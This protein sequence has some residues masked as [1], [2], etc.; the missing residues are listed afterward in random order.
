MKPEGHKSDVK[1]PNVV[2]VLTDDQGYGDVGCHGNPALKTPCL[3][4]LHAESVRFDNFHVAPACSP[5]RAGLLTGRYPISTG[6]WHTRGGHSLLR[7]NE[8]TLADVFRNAGYATGLFGKW[9]LGDGFP[10]RPQD[11]GFDETLIHGGGSVGATADHWGNDC[12]DD[13]YLRNG[14]P[15]QMHGYCT[16]IWFQEATRFVERH[17]GETRSGRAERPFF[18]LI[19][20]NAVHKPYHVPER[21]SESYRDSVPQ[22]RADFFGMI[23]CVDEN[24]GRLR[25][26]LDA[27]G[28]AENTVFVFMSDNGTSGGCHTDPETGH[29]DDGYNAGMRGR[30]GDV[31]E[32]G[33]RVPCFVHWSAGGFAGGSDVGRLASHID[34]LPTLCALCGIPVR[35]PDRLHG[36]SLVPLMQGG[37]DPQVLH[38]AGHREAAKVGRGWQDR[39]VVTDYQGVDVPVKWRRSCV[40]TDRWRLINGT[41]LYDM[42]RDFGQEKDVAK[43]DGDIVAELRESYDEWW[44]MVS[45]ATA[46]QPAMI[47]GSR[48]EPEV[49]IT[50][51]DWRNSDCLCPRN[52]RHIREGLACNGYWQVEFAEKGVYRFELR[53]WPREEAALALSEGLDEEIT[54][55]TG[56]RALKLKHARIKVG[57]QEAEARIHATDHDVVFTLDLPAG[58]ARLETWF[59]DTKGDSIGAYYVY[60]RKEA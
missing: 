52:A 2:F 11:R 28:Q 44:E 39:V 17:A 42:H 9:H 10:F 47:L 7:R 56:G 6:V 49:R 36:R 29:A 53:R 37:T 19:S 23:A 3:D 38:A 8:T 16:D 33:H 34:M 24:V 51:A 22:E 4:A 35:D 60:V 41:E 59:T 25:A 26:R 1:P 40:M 50:A 21:Y 15:E 43:Q 32:G 55:Y 13:V 58:N 46:D 18:C 48:R 12:Y 45:D 57:D 54:P 30:K 20:T 14:K 27:L 5:T 31:Y